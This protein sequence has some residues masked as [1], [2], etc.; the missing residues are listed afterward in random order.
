M[1][2][3]TVGHRISPSL[4]TGL[5]ALGSTQSTAFHLTNNTWH[6]FT[7]V[8]IGS[9]RSCPPAWP[10][11]KLEYLITAPTHSLS[12]RQWAERSTRGRRT[13]LCLSRPA[14]A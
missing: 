11:Q 3:N 6:E 8:P 10:R 5:T 2:T 4:H 13:C 14:M 7:S 9:G 1:S 12:T